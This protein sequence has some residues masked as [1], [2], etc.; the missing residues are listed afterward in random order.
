M[1]VGDASVLNLAHSRHVEKEMHSRDLVLS[2]F[3][4]GSATG[5]S[6]PTLM[7]TVI[8]RLTDDE[9]V[10]HS[11]EFT[12]VNYLP[13]SPV[14]LLSLRPLAELYPDATGRLDRTGTGI[15]SGFDNH[16]LFWNR[17]QFK[18]TFITASS[19]LPE[20]LF[21]S[22][23]SRLK[24]FS[25]ILSSFYDD[26][27]CWALASKEKV[28][29]LANLD[30]NNGDNILTIGDNEVTL[31][32]PVT[33]TNLISFFKDMKLKYNDGQGTRDILTFLGAD[34]GEDMQI[35]C[36]IKLSN[37]LVILVDPESLNFIENPDIEIVLWQLDFRKVN[38]VC[39]TI[40]HSTTR[41]SRFMTLLNSE[42]AMCVRP[43]S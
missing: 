33:L 30:D 28:D 17:E 24:A 27:I 21:N 34:F 36:Q 8:L 29:E 23:Y 37:D 18:K 20:C 41:S 38:R 5:I 2:I 15:R 32:M 43:A 35:K 12:N 40:L 25:T 9:G 14:N 7:G 1:E 42:A 4:V 19:G 16:V 11:F 10:T 39:S 13:D 31:D 26:K 22:G 3:K 6:T